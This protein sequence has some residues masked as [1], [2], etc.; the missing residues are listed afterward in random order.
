MTT[1]VIGKTALSRK[2]TIYMKND[3]KGSLYIPFFAIIKISTFSARQEGYN[4]AVRL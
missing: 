1:I 3:I 4:D 2:I